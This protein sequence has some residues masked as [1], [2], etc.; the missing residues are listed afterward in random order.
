VT[1]LEVM[2]VGYLL[3]WARRKA[4]R[5]GAAVDV[6]ADRVLDASLAKLHQVVS[7]HLGPDSG[8][9]RMDTADPE[10]VSDRVRQRVE[11]DVA[12]AVADDTG[13]AAELERSVVAVQLA[14]RAAGVSLDVGSNSGVV[15]GRDASVQATGG[16]VAALQMRDVSLG[17]S[18][19]GQGSG[20][21][22]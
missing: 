4:G 9:A 17:G 5:V 11:L 12:D 2:A 14:E 20:D 3:A 18:A 10:A 19:G 6:E 7:D 13:F 8:L 21:P 15:V 16:G 1:G 22:R